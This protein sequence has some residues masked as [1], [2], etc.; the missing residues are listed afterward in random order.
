MASQPQPDVQSDEKEEQPE[1]AEEEQLEHAEVPSR[2][3]RRGA[4]QK[5]TAEQTASIQ[6]LFNKD[7]NA[8]SKAHGKDKLLSLNPG[9][10]IAI[11][12]RSAN[13]KTVWMDGRGHFLNDDR[14]LAAVGDGFAAALALGQQLLDDHQLSFAQPERRRYGTVEASDAELEADGYDYEEGDI[15]DDEEG[16]EGQG[17]GFDELPPRTAGARSTAPNLPEG[18]E[19]VEHTGASS[20]AAAGA[21]ASSHLDGMVRA[22]EQTAG[23]LLPPFISISGG[24]S[25]APASVSRPFTSMSGSSMDVPASH[26]QAFHVLGSGAARPQ[27]PAVFT[28][29]A[30]QDPNCAMA[31]VDKFRSTRLPGM[32]P[33]PLRQ[34]QGRLDMCAPSQGCGLPAP[35]E[36]YRLVPELPKPS[37]LLVLAGEGR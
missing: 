30:A 37:R 32:Q 17:L 33:E 31:D 28:S 6:A 22:A 23:R 20:S 2:K 11:L 16:E 13:G 14:V 8:T 26:S 7:P 36:T 3:R 12:I 34:S 29:G 21:R 35:F 15:F 10:E 27:L 25:G 19:P 24:S 18:S 4:Q 5:L 1:L 9:S